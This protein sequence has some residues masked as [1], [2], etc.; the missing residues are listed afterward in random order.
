M[1]GRWRGE[2]AVGGHMQ[3]GRGSWGVDGGQLG[4]IRGSW[5]WL[6]GKR[7]LEGSWGVLEGS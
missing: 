6:G 4:G 7:D 3:G 5:G 1:G 2:E